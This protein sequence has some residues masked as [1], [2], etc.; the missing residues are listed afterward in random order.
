M[1]QSRGVGGGFMFSKSSPSFFPLCAFLLRLPDLRVRKPRPF[2][3]TDQT[4]TE[5][6]PL[7]TPPLAPPKT[8]S[9]E[10]GARTSSQGAQVIPLLS[11]S[12]SLCLTSTWLARRSPIRPL[13][14]QSSQS[15]VCFYSE[16]V[17]HSPAK[18]ETCLN[19]RFFFVNFQSA[20]LL[21]KKELSE[22]EL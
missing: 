17:G 8:S 1:F 10:G 5:K 13:R 15:L 7:V 21:Q 20:K 19:F 11:L 16:R 18:C 6:S 14:Q 3:P 4:I 12:L 9:G 2:F 22:G